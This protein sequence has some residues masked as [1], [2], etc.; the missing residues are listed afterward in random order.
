MSL[1][2][3][4]SKIRFDCFQFIIL[5]CV[6]NYSSLIDSCDKFKLTAVLYFQQSSMTSRDVTVEINLL[7]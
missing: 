6:V 5:K 2:I 1:L 7:L 4:F 3:S